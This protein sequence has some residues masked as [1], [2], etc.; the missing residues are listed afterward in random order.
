MSQ[1]TDQRDELVHD[2]IDLIEH[3]DSI[4][5]RELEFTDMGMKQRGR[6]SGIRRNGVSH[7]L[8]TVD[9]L[10]RLRGDDGWVP[11]IREER[12]FDVANRSFGFPDD[13]RI[14]ATL[15]NFV[16]GTILPLADKGLLD[17]SE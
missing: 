9:S 6:V 17:T 2:F 10:Y 16:A 1:T 8:I 15:P 5:G 13:G 7:T 11:Y 12:D 3:K 14:T 4:I